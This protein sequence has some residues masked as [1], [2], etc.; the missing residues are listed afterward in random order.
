VGLEKVDLSIME[1]IRDEGLNHSHIPE[2]ARHLMD[3]IGPRLTGSPAMKRANEWT[4]QKMREYVMENV[5]LEAYEFGRG[6]E[7]VS[8][9]GRMTVPFIR[10]LSGRPLAW[11]GSTKGLQAGPAVVVKAGS[12]EDMAKYEEKLKGAWVLLGEAAEPRKPSFEPRPLRWP[13]EELLAPPDPSLQK[14]L[15]LTEEQRRQRK[16]EFRRRLQLQSKLRESA[17]LGILRRSSFTGGIVRGSSIMGDVVGSLITPRDPEILPNIMLAD[18]DYSLIYRNVEHGIPVALEFDIQNRFLEGDSIAYNTIGEIPGTDKRG[19]VVI[20]GGHLDSWHMGT[21]ATD[22]GAGSV[23]MLEAVRIL[24]AIGAR[25]HRTIRIAL[26][27][28]E[29]PE[30]PDRNLLGSSAYVQAHKD[31]LNKISVYLNVDSGT[32]RIRGILSQMNPYAIPIFEQLLRPFRD[33]GVLAVRDENSEGSDHES[34]D[35]VGVPAFDF[36]QDPIEY[37]TKTHHTNIDTFDAL[38]LDDLKQAAVVVASTVYHL[39]MRDAM[40]PRKPTAK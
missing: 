4:A 32:G 6:W 5:H 21:G 18:E 20:L 9:F 14:P 17:A 1:K 12:V 8:Y 23:V 38:V 10:P 37:H 34:F 3:V 15:W 25:P 40:F 19:E 22:N 39:A 28:G 2:D 33:L 29:E 26:W 35:R 31:E 16:E 7:E 11:T 24:K 36:I 30:L 13:L 27:S